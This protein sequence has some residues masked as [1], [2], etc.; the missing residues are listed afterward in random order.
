[1]GILIMLLN[2]LKVYASKLRQLE[3]TGVYTVLCVCVCV[4][5]CVCG[6]WVGG[7]VCVHVVIDV[8]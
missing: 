4:C 6:G 2:A 7:W 1:M 3:D 5:V 8:C